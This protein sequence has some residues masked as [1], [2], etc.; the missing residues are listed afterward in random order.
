M[1]RREFLGLGIGLPFLVDS[2]RN[3]GTVYDEYCRLGKRDVLKKVVDRIGKYFCDKGL[4]EFSCPSGS[5]GTFGQFYFPDN[6]EVR[7]E[8]FEGLDEKDKER[9]WR[10]EQLVEIV[11][12]KEEI[13][14]KG[15]ISSRCSF[16]LELD[17]RYDSN[18]F[19]DN[20]GFRRFIIDEMRNFGKEIAGKILGHGVLQFYLSDYAEGV[21]VRLGVVD[22]WER[23]CKIKLTLESMSGDKYWKALFSFRPYHTFYFDKV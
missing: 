22:G 13:D 2:L 16:D 6:F 12:S 9:L 14:Y 8:F 17:Q 21:G 20:D 11:E 3:S 4:I 15:K 5:W 7:E 10:E 18:E 19:M 23:Y 1:E